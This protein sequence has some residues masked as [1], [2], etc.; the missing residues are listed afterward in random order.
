MH[1]VW[2]PVLGYEGAY[3]VSNLGRVRSLPR[4][5]GSRRGHLRSIPGK[6]KDGSVSERTGYRSVHLYR[7]QKLRNV[8]VHRLVADAFIPNP[9]GLPQ[10][11]H[12][13]G[14]KLN[15]EASNLEWCSREEN[16]RH[17]IETGLLA[18]AGSDNPRAIITES[19]AAEI[20]RALRLG[21]RQR[22]LA[23]AF[24]VGK[25]VVNSIHIGRTWKHV[26]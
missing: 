17:A 24:G 22:D 14:N 11:N 12:K 3:E 23:R 5:V 10:V 15:N 20:K 6:L 2:K 16:M 1:E 13:D 4:K 8:S 25:H 7:S 19:D 9:D 21:V 18:T 26:A